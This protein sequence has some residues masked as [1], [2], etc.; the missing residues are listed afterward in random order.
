M[1][2]IDELGEGRKE[3]L[4]RNNKTREE[5]PQLSGLMIR[6]RNLR[7]TH[8]NGAS[9][10]GMKFIFSD[11]QYSVNIA[12]QKSGITSCSCSMFPV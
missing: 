12:L 3:M 1:E 11:F 8:P 5:G 2:Q 7:R 9:R 6:E 4:P 10:D